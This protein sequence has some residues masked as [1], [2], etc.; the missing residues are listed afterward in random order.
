MSNICIQVCTNIF[1][2]NT[3]A[4]K[5]YVCKNLKNLIQNKYLVFISSDKNFCVVNLKRSDYDKK[6]QSMI[7]EKITNGTCVPTRK[8][9]P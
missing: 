6:L 2:K 7:D 9:Y 8:T 3:S 4:T 5:D 1:T